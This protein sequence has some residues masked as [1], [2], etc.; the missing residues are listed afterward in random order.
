[1]TTTPGPECR[2]PSVHPYAEHDGRV[3]KHYAH[4]REKHPYFC[5]TMCRPCFPFDHVAFLLEDYRNR[6]AHTMSTRQVLWV[7]LL[8]CEAYEALE[9]ICKGDKAQAVEE[10]Y[11]AV[12]VLL[13]AIDVLEGRQTL[14]KPKK[15]G[16]AE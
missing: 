4:A 7:D 11:D 16:G 14:G 13:R 9:A 3:A 12:A 15:E 1:M 10:L 2:E 6:I 8:G 5:D